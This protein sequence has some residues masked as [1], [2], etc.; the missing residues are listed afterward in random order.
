MI[1]SAVLNVCP[2]RV[3]QKPFE[4]FVWE[5][6]LKPELSLELLRWLEADAP[7]K[8]IEADFYEQFEFSLFEAELPKSMSF[9]S[10]EDFL[11]FVRRRIEQLFGT[12]LTKKIGCWLVTAT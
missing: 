9:L 6:V 11:Y 5:N 7:W 12:R 2:T 8:L 4:H 1:E 10:R 3:Y